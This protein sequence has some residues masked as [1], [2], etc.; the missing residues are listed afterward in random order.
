MIAHLPKPAF[1]YVHGVDGLRPWLPSA[2]R[3]EQFARLLSSFKMPGGAAI[4]ERWRRYRIGAGLRSA[5]GLFANSGATAAAIGKLYGLSA[6]SFKIVH[7]GVDPRFLAIAR[8]PRGEEVRLLTVARLSEAARRKNVDGVLEALSLLR[9]EFAF[10]Y[11]IVGDGTD[12]HRLEQK[13]SDLGLGN[14]VEFTGSLDEVGIERQYGWADI[15]VLAVKPSPLDVEGFGMVYAEA[16]C[17]G[18]PSLAV[19]SGGVREAVG[20]GLSGILLPDA[21]T[22]SIAAGLRRFAG[23]RMTFDE[24]RIRAFGRARTAPETSRGLMRAI[25]GSL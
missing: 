15:F 19:D 25:T 9:D 21:S 17:A 16:A 6:S 7:P 4:M 10:K 2:Y 12:R 11:R 13:A 5:R 14:C 8:E 1:G 3:I 23:S 24:D 22:A 20:D 18:V